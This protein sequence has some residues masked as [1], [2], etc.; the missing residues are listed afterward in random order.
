MVD[1][2]GGDGFH[3]AGHDWGG[4]VAWALA[5]AHPDRVRSLTVLSTPHPKAMLRSMVTS[6]QALRS[7]YMFFYQLPVIADFSTTGPNRRLFRR[8][9]VGS[10]L[11]ESRVDAYLERFGTRRDLAPINNWYRAM[12]LTRPSRYAPV[13]VPTTY[14]Y[15]TDDF[16][17]GRKAADL[18]GRYVSGP[19]R[20]E[21]LEGVSRW[22]P[23]ERP[24]D[25]ARLILE[26]VR[27]G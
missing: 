22:I 11:A 23:D 5:T 7:W 9:L 19:Y 2:A 15:S 17:L 6:G 26:R 18:T 25:A 13:T 3:V 27:A 1:A 12:P 21:V 4:A 8:T 16:A 10:G 24:E 20:Y 14:V